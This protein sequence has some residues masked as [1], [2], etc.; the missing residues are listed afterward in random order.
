MK[1]G[2]K[3]LDVPLFLLTLFLTAFGVIMVFSSSSY[4]AILQ[5]QVSEYH[6]AVRQ[7]AFVIVGLL[8]GLVIMKIPTKL[9]NKRFMTFILICLIFAMAAL[10]TY[11]SISHNAKS[12]FSVGPVSIQPSEF[13]KTILILFLAAMYG[14]TKKFRN[15]YDAFIPLVGAAAVVGM[16]LLEPDRG[17]AMIIA[18]ITA[19]IFLA[20]PLGKKKWFKILRTLSIFGV[21]AIIGVVVFFPNII[22]SGEV[23][24][25]FNYR[26]PCSR[27]LEDTGYQVCNGY[28]ALN[29]GGTFGLGLGKSTQKYL[30]LPE[31]HTDFIFAIIVEELGVL[32]GGILLLAYLLLL[33]RILVIARNAKNLRNSIIAFG[34]FAYILIHIMVN[35]GGLLALIPL[36]GVPLPF[37]SYGGSFMLNLLI[38]VSLTQR[39]AIENKEG[40]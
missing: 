19:F 17:T 35:L 37:L 18:G 5:Y 15:D 14:T 38:L 3:N 1:K 26:N 34:T 9:Y 8:L 7:A 16:V 20:L 33:F 2:I 21:I 13:A 29:N 24:S 23:A 30:Y 28:I 22:P 11:G 4:S 25:R 39:V 6:F 10:Q 31:A 36:T 32:T 27:Y 12:W 40:N